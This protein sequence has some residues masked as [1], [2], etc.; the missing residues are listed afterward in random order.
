LKL[1]TIGFTQRSAQEFFESIRSSGIKL[2]LDI[3]LNNA[4]QLAGFTKGRDLPFF[5][6]E[7]CHCA[8]THDIRYS[9][10]K[11]IL[12]DY[13]NGK[14]PW[15]EYADRFVKLLETRNVLLDFLSDYGKNQPVCLLC[16]EPTSEYC[17]RGIVAEKLSRLYNLEIT[18]L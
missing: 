2:V 8:Y 5:L 9:P 6:N 1:Y 4:S 10:T 13:K 15:N 18:H 16:S 14:I 12:D 11:E 17:H 3:R 7:L